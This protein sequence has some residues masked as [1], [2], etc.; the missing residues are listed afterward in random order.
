MKSDI[1]IKM[2][3]AREQGHKTGFQKGHAEGY[4]KGI[5]STIKNY[6]SVV[7]LCLKDKFDFTADELHKV[8]VSINNTFD[9]I[10]QDYLTL[11][12][13]SK[14]LK[15]ED[16]I[17]LS[18]DGKVVD[19][20]RDCSEFLYKVSCLP[21]IDALDRDILDKVFKHSLDPE[22]DLETQLR[23]VGYFGE[24]KDVSSYY[25]GIDLASGE[26]EVGYFDE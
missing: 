17:E 13:I 23:E 12:D 26:D 5:Q 9:S 16:N 4:T 19:P 14:T 3:L 24:F 25:I 1:N 20:D 10:C 6:S 18:F 21:R 2:R 15:E 7:L 22:Q 8:A 11:D